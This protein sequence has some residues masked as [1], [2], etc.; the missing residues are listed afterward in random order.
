MRCKV[1]EV[2]IAI[3]AG[4][5]VALAAN[6]LAQDSTHHRRFLLYQMDR[7]CV[8]IA[9][10][11]RTRTATASE[12]RSGKAMYEVFRS[13]T[14]PPR[15]LFRVRVGTVVSGDVVKWWNYGIADEADFNGDGRPDYS[16]YGGDD[17]SFAMYLFLSSGDQYRQVDV[18]KTIQAA[19]RQRFHTAAPDLADLGGDYNLRDTV[20][21]QTEAGLVL[22]VTVDRASDGSK[23]KSYRF[24]IPEAD[25]K[26]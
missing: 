9:A 10:K 18:L 6:A 13:R 14:V 17:T 11:K 20:L 12:I 7:S 1:L 15:E 16:W 26:P 3:M 5:V 25:F 4:F 2:K 19:W 23:T 21:D 8:C 22:L 24:R